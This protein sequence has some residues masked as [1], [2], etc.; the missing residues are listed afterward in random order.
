MRE[1]V[2]NRDTRRK[3]GCKRHKG[4][5]RIIEETEKK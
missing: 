5:K 4:E 1:R 2:R 3:K